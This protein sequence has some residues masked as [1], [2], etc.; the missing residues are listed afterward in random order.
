MTSNQ[1]YISIL[2]PTRNNEN[3]LMDCLKSVGRLDY[4]PEMIRTIIWDNNSR[5]ESKKAVRD[6]LAQMAPIYSTQVE[7]IENSDN[8]GVYTSRDELCKRVTSDTQFVLSIDDDVILPPNLLNEL[9]HNFQHDSS[10]GI[11]G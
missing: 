4:P 11:I 5:L 1:A 10:I 6:Y 3:D 2:I 7:F 8:Y 9:I